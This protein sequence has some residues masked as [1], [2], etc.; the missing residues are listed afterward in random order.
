M[1]RAA[2]TLATLSP[3]QRTEAERV[4]TAYVQRPTAPKPH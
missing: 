1:A 2:K 3:E 4:T